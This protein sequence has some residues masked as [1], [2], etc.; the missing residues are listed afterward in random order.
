MSITPKQ[1]LVPESKW[2][3]KCP[4]PMTAEHIT[5][6]NTANKASAYNEISYMISNDSTTSYHFAV[7]DKEVI[8]A[9]PVNRNAFHAG[10]GA[11][12]NGNRKSISIEICYS[13]NDAD[14]EKFK[15]AEQ[16]AAKFIAQLLDERNWGIDK[17]KKHQDW[18]GKYCLPLDAT[19][20]LTPNGWVPL[21]DLMEG[22]LVAQWDN[23]KIEFAPIQYIIAPYADEVVKCRNIEATLNHDIVYRQPKS[24]MWKKGKWSEVLKKYDAIIPVGGEYD[25][26][27]LPI[28]DDYLRFLVWVQ[29]DGHY[30]KRTSKYTGTVHSLG[31]EFHFAKE[32]KVKQLV[33]VLE[34]LEQKYTLRTRSDG[35]YVIRIHDATKVAEVEQWLDNK[36]FS[37]KF[38]EMDAHQRE[39]FL[40]EILLADG[41]IE[42]CSYFSTKQQ[43]YDIVSAV[44]ALNNTRCLQTTTGSSTALIF[45]DSRLTV[46]KTS[47]QQTRR[48][49]VS[50]VEVPSHN[51]LIRQYGR[52][53]VVGN[54]PHRTLDMGWQRF[55]DMIS[56]ELKALQKPELIWAPTPQTSY[57]T[58]VYTALYDI[59]NGTVIR[60]FGS[61]VRLD[62]VEQTTY[63]GTTYF[64]TPYSRDHN[65]NNGVPA[66]D[67]AVYTPEETRLSWTLL[68]KPTS[69]VALRDCKLID[70]KTGDIK[71][72]YELGETIEGL[73]DFTEFEGETYLR[74]ETIK[75]QKKSWA[76]SLYQLGDVVEPAEE[77][78]SPDGLIVEPPEDSPMVEPARTNWVVAL[79]TIIINFIKGLLGKG[80]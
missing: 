30:A 69:K 37:W 60:S 17:V 58:L 46:S 3:I 42:N 4:Y 36:Q 25:G 48:T 21:G 45:T 80:K 26:R 1:M 53:V 74:S 70:L 39:I 6:H 79:F 10:D 54:C 76:I 61:D 72:E 63:N 51:I 7:D 33:E 11:T 43:N 20:L 50:C 18:S 57:I 27:G 64:R 24:A 31:I 28:S 12:G 13:L 77:V 73:V 62:F 41:S 67:L 59:T 78:S 55:L 32:R 47:E 71:K 23:D 5:V 35:T 56:A 75:N 8:Q 9:I 40:S 14:I 2:G 49:I 16:L 34:A 44:A 65:V 22:D 29:A 52:P 15:K 19:E 66:S 68:E 38:L